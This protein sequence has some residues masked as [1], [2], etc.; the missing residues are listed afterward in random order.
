MCWNIGKEKWGGMERVGI[1]RRR[2]CGGMGCVGE[3]ES[4]N[5]EKR[6]E[7]E[8]RKM[9]MRRSGCVGVKKMEKERRR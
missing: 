9:K 5:E 8:K 2:K 6:G 4:E 3:K 1:E 7:L